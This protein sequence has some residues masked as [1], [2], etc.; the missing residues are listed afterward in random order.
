MGRYIATTMRGRG[1]GNV[2]RGDWVATMMGGYAATMMR[3]RCR[4]RWVKAGEEGRYRYRVNTGSSVLGG[5]V[6]HGGKKKSKLWAAALD[7]KGVEKRWRMVAL[8][9]AN[10]QLKPGRIS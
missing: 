9:R 7:L 3:G 5:V 8:L 10:R 1:R 4:G 6:W 2:L